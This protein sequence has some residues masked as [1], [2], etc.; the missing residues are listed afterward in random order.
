MTVPENHGCRHR[1]F[2]RQDEGRSC[3]CQRQE[4]AHLP[5]LSPVHTQQNPTGLSSTKAKQMHFLSGAEIVR[6]KAPRRRGRSTVPGTRLRNGSLQPQAWDEQHTEVCVNLNALNTRK[7]PPTRASNLYSTFP[8]NPTR[9]PV[10]S[11]TARQEL[12]FTAHGRH[13]GQETELDGPAHPRFFPS[14]Q[15]ILDSEMTRQSSLK[16]LPKKQEL[17]KA[18]DLKE[19]KQPVRARQGEEPSDSLAQRGPAGPG[20]PEGC[21]PA[22]ARA[23]GLRAAG[24]ARPAPGHQ[25]DGT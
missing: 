5:P 25:P 15:Q 2:T 12:P 21:A 9:L 20:R 11:D 1:P 16:R 14:E 23:R 10:T 4:T 6:R 13:G 22:A 17:S 18:A 24:R 3:F 19:K 7:M 8:L